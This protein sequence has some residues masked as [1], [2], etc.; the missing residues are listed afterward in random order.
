MFYPIFYD[1]YTG[2]YPSR[3]GFYGDALVLL[4]WASRGLP[5]SEVTMAEALKDIGYKTGF[6]GKWH[7]GTIDSDF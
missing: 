5:K 7:L 1:F 4:P 6:I 2:R 3:F